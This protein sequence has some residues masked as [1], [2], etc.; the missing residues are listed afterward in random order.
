MFSWSART[1]RFACSV[2]VMTRR[3]ERRRLVAGRLLRRHEQESRMN[4]SFLW[5][6]IIRLA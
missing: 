2:V 6:T 3:A 4:S 1:M 5:L